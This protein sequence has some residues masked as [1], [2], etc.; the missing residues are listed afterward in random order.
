MAVSLCP[1]AWA[2]QWLQ[3]FYAQ[4]QLWKKLSWLDVVK[5]YWRSFAVF[6]PAL[7]ANQPVPGH[8]KFSQ[9]A[10]FLAVNK[11]VGRLAQCVGNLPISHP[12]G[13]DRPGC[14]HGFFLKFSNGKRWI[15]THFV[16]Q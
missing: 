1:V 11:W 4:S 15:F 10:P 8:C 5:I 9:V 12:G 3:V 13:F 14:A 16:L 2:T 6:M 7:A